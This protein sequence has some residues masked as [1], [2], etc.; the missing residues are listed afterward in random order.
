MSER[1]RL[2]VLADLIRKERIS[3]QMELKEHLLA[4]GYETTQS[5]I[6]RDLKKLGV[7]KV[8][9]AYKT[10]SIAPGESSKVDR[11][12]AVTAGDNMIVLRTGPGNANRA[13]VIIDRA[14]LSGLLGTIAGDDTI[15]CAVANRQEQAKV[16]KKIFTLFE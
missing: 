12:D 8:D 5:S 2:S 3:N 7:V 15:F 9:G 13:A 14:N 16:L 1:D 11:L 10:P 6:S 4:H